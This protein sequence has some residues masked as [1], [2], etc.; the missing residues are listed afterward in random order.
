MEPARVPEAP[1][2]RTVSMARRCQLLSATVLFWETTVE[3]PS[4]TDRVALGLLPSGSP[5][6]PKASMRMT[7]RVARVLRRW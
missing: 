6:K 3:P 7:L 4:F 1:E 2:V 5:K